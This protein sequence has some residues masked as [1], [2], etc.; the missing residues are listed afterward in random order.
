MDHIDFRAELPETLDRETYLKLY[1]R[2]WATIR[3]DLFKAIKAEKAEGAIAQERFEK[4][5]EAVLDRFDEIRSQLYELE[6]GVKVTRPEEAR[7]KMQKAY[8]TFAS[9][10]NI[11]PDGTKGLRSRWPDLVHE[12]AVRHN[13]YL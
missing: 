12:A 9:Q 1:R 8:I 6:L 7:T 4:L 10:P 3:H 5:Y 2:I 13:D 11:K